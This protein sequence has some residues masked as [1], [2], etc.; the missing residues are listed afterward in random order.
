[1]EQ[2]LQVVLHTIDALSNVAVQSAVVSWD[3]TP[4]PAIVVAFI[5]NVAVPARVQ[6]VPFAE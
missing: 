3:V 4:K 5:V 6:V 1:M 2:R